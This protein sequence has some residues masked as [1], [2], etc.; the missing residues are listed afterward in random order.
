MFQ[1]TETCAITWERSHKR[2]YWGGVGGGRP[3]ITNYYWGGWGIANVHVISLSTVEFMLSP[4]PLTIFSAKKGGWDFE[5]RFDPIWAKKKGGKF[6]APYF[7]WR[8][9][10][11]VGGF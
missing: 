9:S 5:R 7:F 4:P 6:R 2:S 3:M 1:K 8:K 11:K 10:S